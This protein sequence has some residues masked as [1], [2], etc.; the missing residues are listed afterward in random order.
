MFSHGRGAPRAYELFKT[1]ASSIGALTVQLTTWTSRQ[2]SM[3]NPSRFV[4]TFT[5][6]KV[7]RSTPVARTAKWPQSRRETSRIV[8]LRQFFSAIALLPTIG[9]AGG[10][11]GTEPD[12]V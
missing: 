7:S 5:L 1:I 2:Q 10:G 11:A 9:P 8:T 6:S 3:S 4:S 12:D